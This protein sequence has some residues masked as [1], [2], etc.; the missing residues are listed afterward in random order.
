MARYMVNPE[1]NILLN[2]CKDISGMVSTIPDF[3]GGS[4]KQ[5]CRQ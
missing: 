5:R 1:L 2:N 4:M 3:L